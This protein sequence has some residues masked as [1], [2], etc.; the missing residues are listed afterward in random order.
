MPPTIRSITNAPR[1]RLRIRRDRRGPPD[2]NSASTRSISGRP[3]SAAWCGDS[4]LPDSLKRDRGFLL[5]IFV[6][7][8][9]VRIVYLADVKGS[10]Y[11]DHPLLDSAWYDAK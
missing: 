9:V 11:F 5:A 6:L 2:R 10:P 1:S 8:L 3:L 4:R 7:A